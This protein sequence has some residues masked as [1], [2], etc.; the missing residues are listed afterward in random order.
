MS[1]AIPS[2]V[3]PAVVR[4]IQGVALWAAFGAVGACGSESTDPGAAGRPASQASTEAA[5]TQVNGQSGTEYGPGSGGDR[6]ACPCGGVLRNPLRA[7]V[8]EVVG[9]IEGADFR[10]VRLGTVR[11]R[12]DELL[13]NTTGLEIGSEISAPWFGELP[14]YYGCALVA[15]GDEVLAFYRFPEPCI[16][17]T[18]DDCPQGDTSPPVI[19]LTPWSDRPVLAAL[20]SGDFTVAL[21]ELSSLDSPECQLG[22]VHDRLGPN[23]AEIACYEREAR[24]P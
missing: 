12:V 3:H 9:H 23:D 20:Q 2:P 4:T 11:L 17:I 16:N 10:P 1:E 7:T 21:D 19:A 8:L 6:P 5:Q 22:T 15:V 18:G 24:A 14:C 13:G